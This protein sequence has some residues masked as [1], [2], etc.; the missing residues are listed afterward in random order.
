MTDT[1]VE[2]NPILAAVAEASAAG[3]DWAHRRMVDALTD[4]VSAPESMRAVVRAATP[5][6]RESA[7][8]ALTAVDE[9]GTSRKV[10]PVPVDGVPRLDERAIAARALRSFA[11]QPLTPSRA[12]AI[13]T[14]TECHKRGC[15]CGNPTPEQM[16]R[17]IAAATQDAARSEADRIEGGGDL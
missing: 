8:A 7:L 13:A 3:P 4:D 1:T 6:H 17:E 5:K 15:A 10:R 16:A 9:T 11:E 14:A 2:E 12:M